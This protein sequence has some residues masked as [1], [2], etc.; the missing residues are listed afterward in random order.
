M[1]SPWLRFSCSACRQCEVDLRKLDRHR[2]ATIESLIPALSCGRFRPNPPFTKF[3]GSLQAAELFMTLE[4][5]YENLLKWTE[6]GAR[7]ALIGGI[8]AVNGAIGA[9]IAA[10]PVIR[11]WIGQ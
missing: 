6:R 4:E 2:G 1:K 9:W 7:A 10:W 11:D 5:Q 8:A 3:V